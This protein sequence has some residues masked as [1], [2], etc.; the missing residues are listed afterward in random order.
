MSSAETQRRSPY[1][2][3]IPYSEAD[4]PFFFG[5]EK[6]TRLIIANLFGSPLTLLYGASGVGKSSVLRAGVAHQLCEREDL[7]VAVFNSWQ[8]DPVTDLIGSVAVEADHADPSAW[9]KAWDDWGRAKGLL[10]D[11]RWPSLAE[12][13][14]ICAKQLNRRLMIIL[15]QFEEYFLYHPKDDEFAVEFSR[16]VTQS[17][18]PVSFLISI[19]ED[20]YAKLDR[21][22]GRIPTLYDNYLRIEHLDRE[23]ARVAVEQ[24]I[25]QYNRLYSRDGEQ[26]SIEPELVEAVLQ[27]VETGRV[28]LEAQGLVNNHLTP[29]SSRSRPN[30]IQERSQPI[31]SPR[32]SLAGNPQC[33]FVVCG[34]GRHAVSHSLVS[35]ALRERETLLGPG[36]IVERI[37]ELQIWIG[38]GITG[39]RLRSGGGNLT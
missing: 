6:E 11:N 24:P 17:D 16:A 8:G 31:P 37:I 38:V 22:E 29:Q 27:Q 18:A 19:R 1:Q 23:A 10:P 30:G 32:N 25:A 34:T 15:D 39:H 4:A 13:L 36:V 21:F 14:T 33:F 5:R 2:G 3:L 28:I 35:D 12:F 9:K 20:F 26:F 7:L